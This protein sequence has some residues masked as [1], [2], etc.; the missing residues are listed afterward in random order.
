MRK[1]GLYLLIAVGLLAGCQKKYTAMDTTTAQTS[2]EETKTTE[3]AKV[4]VSEESKTSG[5]TDAKEPESTGKLDPIPIAVTGEYDGEW[6]DSQT[7]IITSRC[8]RVFVQGDGYEA[9]KSALSAKNDEMAAAH[10]KE[11]E[12]Y[13][14]EAIDMRKEF[15]DAKFTYACN[16]EFQP[17]RFD[18]A[19]ASM[20]WLKYYDMGGAHPTAYNDYYNFDTQTGKQLELSDMVKDMDGFRSYVKEELAADKM[21]LR[22]RVGCHNGKQHCADGAGNRDRHGDKE[23]CAEL[24]RSQ[25]VFYGTGLEPKRPKE[26]LAR[27]DVAFAAECF[28]HKV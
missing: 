17:I 10:K 18:G 16:Y 6:D 14:V 27:N 20:S 8:D 3:S 7:P 25:D 4:T 24:R 13:K 26:H 23:R 1:Y 5:E 19:V 9:L 12:E 22:E 28:C 15:T 2:A 11:Y 21:R